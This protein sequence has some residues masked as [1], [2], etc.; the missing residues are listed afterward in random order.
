L[1]AMFDSYAR[2]ALGMV[3]S[4][5]MANAQAATSRVEEMARRAFCV[6]SRSLGGALR[7]RLAMRP[8]RS[9]ARVAL[10]AVVPS[11]LKPSRAFSN[12]LRP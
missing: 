10:C 3:P 12:R 5:S 8:N 2:N 9:R 7:V 4:A 1:S 6:G 11:G